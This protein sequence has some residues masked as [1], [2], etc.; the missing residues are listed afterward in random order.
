VENFLSGIVVKKWEIAKCRISILYKKTIDIIFLFSWAKRLS[1]RG[2]KAQF[3][4]AAAVCRLIS[5]YAKSK[6]MIQ[7]K[8]VTLC[9]LTKF[10]NNFR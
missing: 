3:C 6:E 10:K 2:Q 7:S 8:Q 1:R 4:P 9:K 5:V